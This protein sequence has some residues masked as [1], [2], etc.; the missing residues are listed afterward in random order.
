MSALFVKSRYTKSRYTT[1]DHSPGDLR[2]AFGEAVDAYENWTGGEPQPWVEL[3]DQQLP[4]SRVAG[5]AL[6]VSRCR[7][8]VAGL[9]LQ[10]S[11]GLPRHNA[12][13]SLLA[14]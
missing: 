2:D 3:R 7:S 12:V 6:Q 1:G 8:R 9:A 4:I 11:C 14:D 13:Q 10:V 5:L